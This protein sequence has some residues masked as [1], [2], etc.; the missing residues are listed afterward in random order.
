VVITKGESVLQYLKG[1][2]LI[3]RGKANGIFYFSNSIIKLR[4]SF[5]LAVWVFP[6]YFYTMYKLQIAAVGSTGNLVAF[7]IIQISSY[8]IYWCAYPVVVERL[9]GYWHRQ[10]YYSTYII[11]YNYLKGVQILLAAILLYCASNIDMHEYFFMIANLLIVL[12]TVVA[13]W[14]IVRFG[15]KLGGIMPLIFLFLDGFIGLFITS[16]AG[17]L[18]ARI[19]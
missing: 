17:A 3:L 18:L 5:W 9:I 6:I 19:I 12:I 7:I 16:L 13:E 1:L 10:Q 11:M 8:V 14:N 15:L 4:Q 2:W